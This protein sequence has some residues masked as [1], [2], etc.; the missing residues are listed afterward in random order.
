MTYLVL[1]VAFLVIA[2]V[3]LLVA[4]AS[5][6]DR[7]RIVRRWW[8]PVLVAGVIALILT[9]VFD[10]LMIGSGLM[11][12]R[13]GRISGAQLG[14]VPLEDFAYPVAA[15]LLLPA[16]WLLFRRRER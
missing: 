13:Q 6:P 12:Y 5:A 11:T 3:V 10:N 14:L 15:L 2:A 1:S 16:L 9:A 8:L 7:R 4:L